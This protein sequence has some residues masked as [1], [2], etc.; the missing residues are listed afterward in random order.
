MPSEISVPF[1]IGRDRRVVTV[2]DT[3]AQ[4]R[5]HVR[6]LVNT[7]PNERAGVPGYGVPLN[8]TLFE[9]MD[10]EEIGT[11]AEVMLRQGFEDWEP[12]LELQQVTPDEQE[13]YDNK[14]VLDVRYARRDAADTNVGVA[15]SNTA[16]IGANGTV[17]EA[18]RG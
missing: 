13:S 9:G 15:N 6:A 10:P 2:S 7:H 1:R 18:V 8:T 5:Q 3:D 4:I 14:A 12:G 16:I 11:M 17:R